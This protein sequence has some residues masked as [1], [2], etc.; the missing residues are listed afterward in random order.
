[1]TPEL[2][3]LTD[4]GFRLWTSWEGV[5]SFHEYKRIM[6]ILTE[7]CVDVGQPRD[8]LGQTLLVTPSLLFAKG[9]DPKYIPH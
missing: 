7:L 3:V 6:K 5:S 8:G 1:M 2:D 4:F 9:V